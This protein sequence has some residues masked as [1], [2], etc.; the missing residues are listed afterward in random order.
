MKNEAMR[1]FL[2]ERTLNLHRGYLEDARLRLSILG[3]SGYDIEGKSY[4]ELKNARMRE[5]RDEVLALAA[6]IYYHE[7]YFSSF[8]DRG[9]TCA[10]LKPRYSSTA[11]FLY[12]T[13]RR[14]MKHTDGFILIYFDSK[15]AVISHSEERVPRGC[16]EPCLAIDLSEHAYF[17]DYGFDKLSYV[18]GALSHLDLSKIDKK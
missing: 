10:C 6:D 13:E 4:P 18:R 15:S 16:R 12:E 2:S 5:S 9:T 17:L 11:G 14:A 8:G 1:G 3:K 7:L